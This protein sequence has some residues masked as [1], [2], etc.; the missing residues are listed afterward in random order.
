MS[1]EW[2]IKSYIIFANL[3]FIFTIIGVMTEKQQI[4]IYKFRMHKNTHIDKLEFF[5]VN[6]I[7]NTLSEFIAHLYFPRCK[8]F[9][10]SFI[11][12]ILELFI[13]LQRITI[14]SL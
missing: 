11:K 5:E 7:I 13:C 2:L 3:L 12:V 10:L 4:L 14:N 8:A 6:L 9:T 1:T